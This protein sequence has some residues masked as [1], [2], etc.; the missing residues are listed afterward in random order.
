MEKYL[1]DRYKSIRAT[2]VVFSITEVL[3][4]I[5]AYETSGIIRGLFACIALLQFIMLSIWE[6]K[7]ESIKQVRN[8]K[9]KKL[10]ML[11][12]PTITLGMY[13]GTE[14]EALKYIT[15]GIMVLYIAIIVGGYIMESHNID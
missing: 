4:I 2:R 7:Y 1:I 6:E 9:R 12:V 5:G 15:I 13:I 10:L 11:I 3:C 8:G 14:I